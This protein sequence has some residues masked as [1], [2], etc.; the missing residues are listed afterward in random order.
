MLS[1]PELTTM[2][3][4]LRG[5]RALSVYVD[6]E[7]RDPAERRAWKLQLD[8]AL[9]QLRSRLA[10]STDEE[11][12]M[13]ERSGGRL[14]ER[15]GEP[16]GPDGA[17]GWVAF[18][19]P[20]GV[21]HAER[22]T[23]PTPT[24]VAWEDGVRVAPYI[25]SLRDA[26]P[27]VVFLGDARKVSIYRYADGQL[28]RLETLRARTNAEPPTHMGDTPRVGFHPG[29]RGSTG[30][31]D[32]QRARTHGTD[33]MLDE[34]TDRV[35]RAAGRDAW[36]VVGGI[37]RVV[38]SAAERI[39]RSAPG[40]VLEL[41]AL[42]VHSSES[43]LEEAAREGAATL[44]DALELRRIEEAIEQGTP[45][46]AAAIGLTAARSAL[47]ERRVR[48]LYFT[49]RWLEDHPEDAERVVSAALEQRAA[50]AEVSGE[51]A[52]ILDEHGGVAALLRFARGT[53]RSWDNSAA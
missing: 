52:R 35:A 4:S 6:S 2:A 27:V 38:Q 48:E 33:A 11:R 16:D 30:R 43:Q 45:E 5:E 13:F 14:V 1:Y 19:T 39:T 25:R 36:I 42:D 22:L 23:V 53:A 32:A 24:I 40:R 12:E 37:P 3:R 29:V 46:G 34:A 21:R 17:T 18:V 44:R 8:H 47:E 49:L 26:R 10:N 20:E 7:A 41:E 28:Q 15:L 50:V 31:E 51:A 9:R